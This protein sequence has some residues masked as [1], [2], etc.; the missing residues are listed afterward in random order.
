MVS[1]GFTEGAKI[2]G[3]WNQVLLQKRLKPYSHICLLAPK[4]S[5]TSRKNS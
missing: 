2:D 1:T 5:P 4:L 3:A